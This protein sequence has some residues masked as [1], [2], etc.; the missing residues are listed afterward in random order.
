MDQ[1][2]KKQIIEVIGENILRERKSIE[3]VNKRSI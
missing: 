2:G 3:K 1:K